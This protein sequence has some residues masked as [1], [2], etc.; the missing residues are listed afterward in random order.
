M[1]G[2]AAVLALAAC[3]RIDFDPLAVEGVEPPTIVQTSAV[4]IPSG[5][6]A[7]LSI[8]PT[9]D[10]HLL[11]VA[12]SDDQFTTGAVTGVTDDAGNVY[13]SADVGYPHLGGSFGE[14][15]YAS[16]SHAGASRYRGHHRCED[17]AGRR[18]TNAARR[19]HASGPD[20]VR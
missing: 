19:G 14:L 4:L 17:R 5:T 7:V 18:C 1:R 11:V 16:G 13:V 6:A 10:G 2:L 9:G 15:W 12:T 8:A 20:S 3:G